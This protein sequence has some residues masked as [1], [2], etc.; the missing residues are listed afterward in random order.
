M[1]F[2]CRGLQLSP[3]RWRSWPSLQRLQDNGAIVSGTASQARRRIACRQFCQPSPFQTGMAARRDSVG[4]GWV[5]PAAGKGR[6]TGSTAVCDPG[7]YVTLVSRP[8]LHGRMLFR[9][10]DLQ[11]RV[12]RGRPEEN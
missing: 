12:V 9:S 4:L 1:W 7:E 8:P 5:F 11:E 10:L 3:R 6:G 2:S